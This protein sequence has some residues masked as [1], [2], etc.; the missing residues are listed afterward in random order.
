M[1]LDYK[2][3]D[4]TIDTK[5][6]LFDIILFQELTNKKVLNLTIL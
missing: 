2:L 5:K 3:L 4:N 1:M 6:E